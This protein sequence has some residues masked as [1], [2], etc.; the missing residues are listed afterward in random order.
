LSELDKRGHNRKEGE[1]GRH[2]V[3]SSTGGHM[4][5][6]TKRNE[7]SIR[8]APG[9]TPNPN[10]G[11]CLRVRLRLDVYERE[12]MIDYSIVA[13]HHPQAHVVMNQISLGSGPLLHLD[14]LHEISQS[15]AELVDRYGDPFP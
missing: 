7:L 10:L 2:E 9:A 5:D 1:K 13:W 14:V 8:Q 3:A 15:L 4:P 11:P 12:G 6:D